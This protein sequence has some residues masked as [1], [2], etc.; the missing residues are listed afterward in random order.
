VFNDGHTVAASNEEGTQYDQMT[1][2][3]RNKMTE[4]LTLV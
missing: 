2:K 4:A 3:D 1:L